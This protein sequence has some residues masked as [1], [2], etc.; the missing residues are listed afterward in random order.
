MKDE[1]FLMRKISLRSRRRITAIKNILMNPYDFVNR[2]ITLRL[3][4]TTRDSKDM[5]MRSYFKEFDISNF[6]YGHA[7]IIAGNRIFKQFKDS[8]KELPFDE[9][10]LMT[11]D[12]WVTNP[13]I[14]KFAL[15]EVLLSTIGVYLGTSPILIQANLKYGRKNNFYAG[16]PNF[17]LDRTGLS[18]VRVFVYLSETDVNSGPVSFLSKKDSVKLERSL[19]YLSG[20]LPDSKVFEFIEPS[21]V[22]SV[23]G[24]TGTIFALD[25]SKCFHFG[26]R[27]TEN[28]RLAFVFTYARATS[29]IE[30]CSFPISMQ[31]TLRTRLAR[32]AIRL[33]A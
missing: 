4:P 32:L 24:S 22:F 6:P 1:P 14:V 19:G 30:P 3:A 13:T 12:E 10:E 20:P 26:S 28:D 17:H 25:T 18:A 29:G 23:T 31:S 8:G 5:A 9:R 27:C 15:S 16:S 21:R 11:S 2:K 7:L 33:A